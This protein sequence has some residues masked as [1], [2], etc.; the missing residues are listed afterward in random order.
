MN[1][2][3]SAP[4]S[5]RPSPKVAGWTVSCRHCGCTVL[6]TTRVDDHD[7][8]LLR[9]HLHDCYPH[10]ADQLCGV[11]SIVRHYFSIDACRVGPTGA[12]PH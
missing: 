11:M 1:A 8:R 12:W 6:Q 2:M 3:P 7:V 4:L 10:A 9:R 5:N